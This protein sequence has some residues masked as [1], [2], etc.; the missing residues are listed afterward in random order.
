MSIQ[1][2]VH[3]VRAHQRSGTTPQTRGMK[4]EAGVALETTGNQ[5]LWMGLATTP[6]GLTSGWHH[7]GDCETGLYLLQ[8]FRKG[9]SVLLVD[10]FQ[11]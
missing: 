5:A 10:K 7:H 2:G 8:A 6:A 11:I 3:V 4:R 1:Q 9:Q